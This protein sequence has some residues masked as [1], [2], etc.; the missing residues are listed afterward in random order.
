MVSLGARLF[1]FNF[2]RKLIIE[3]FYIYLKRNIMVFL[4]MSSPRSGCRQ[5]QYFGRWRNYF[6]QLLN[7][8]GSNYVRQTEIRSAKPSV[9]KPRAFEVQMAIRKHNR[10]KPTGINKTP[11]ELIEAGDMA[12]CSEIHESN[13]SIWNKEELPERWKKSIIV[14]L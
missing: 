10:Y 4:P 6:S 1:Y 14:H 13:N 3:A 9:P 7:V 11:T 12:I 5:S 8:H 2:N